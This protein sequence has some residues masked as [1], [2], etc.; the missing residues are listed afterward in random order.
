MSSPVFGE[1]S[2]DPS[3]II[4]CGSTGPLFACYALVGPATSVLQL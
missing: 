4:T 3:P 2:N 1:V